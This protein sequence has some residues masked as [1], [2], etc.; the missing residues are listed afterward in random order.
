MK[1]YYFVPVVERFLM[2]KT[3]DLIVEEYKKF[4]QTVAVAVGGS[5]TAQTADSQSDIDTYVFVE[6]EIPVEKRLQLIKKYSTKY[7]AGC[8]YF[9]AGDEFFVDNMNRQLDV[10]FMDKKWIEDIVENVWEKHYPSNGYTTCFLFTI[11]NCEILYDREGWLKGLKDRLATPYPEELKQNIIKRNMMLLKDKPFASY[12]EQ[13]AKAVT[14]NDMNSVNHRLAAFMA[15][16]FD[17][18]FAMNRLLHPGEKKLVKYALEH[19]KILP[20][21]FE[22]NITKLLTQPNTD[23]LKILRNMVQKLKKCLWIIFNKKR[24]N[25][26]EDITLHEEI[27]QILEAA[28]RELTVA[29][30]QANIKSYKRKVDGQT[31]NTTQIR[32]RVNK[33]PGVFYVNKSNKPHTVGLIKYRQD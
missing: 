17:I 33:R 28:K 14:R 6:N 24:K 15:S 20:E 30:I 5:Q 3:F 12:Y 7:E 11:K 16:Y 23:T 27:E 13:I 21:N 31:P 1:F 8:E 22:E 18:I 19:C 32:A 10:M 9:G 2:D 29:E 25:T 4:Q 26:M